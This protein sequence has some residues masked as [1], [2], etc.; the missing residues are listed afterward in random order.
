MESTMTL[1]DPE[2]SI[3]E[4]AANHVSKQLFK[5]I[6]FKKELSTNGKKVWEAANN[7]IRIP[8]QLSEDY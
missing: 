6:D 7:W 8:V 2:T 5:K 1:I 4:I 3:I